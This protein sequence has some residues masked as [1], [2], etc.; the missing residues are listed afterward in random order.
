MTRHA[1]SISPLEDAISDLT[2]AVG[3]LLR[4]LRIASPGDLNLSQSSVLERLEREGPTATADL[5][6]PN[7]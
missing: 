2:L 4:R 1:E 7:R 6:A 5:R 3:Q